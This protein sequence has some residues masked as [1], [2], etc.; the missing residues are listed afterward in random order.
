MQRHV[1]VVDAGAVE[2]AALGVALRSECIWTKCVRVEKQ[3]T[4]AR[5]AVDFVTRAVVLGHIDARSVDTIVLYLH[6]IVVALRRKRHRHSRGKAGNS[7]E[8]PPA[9]KATGVKE[10]S[11]RHL[12]VVADNE[13]VFEVEGRDAIER[14][15]VVRVDLFLDVR[16]LIVGLRVGVACKESQ[17]PGGAREGHFEAVVLRVAHVLVVGVGADLIGE[18]TARP[19]DHCAIRSRVD[20]IFLKRPTRRRAGG[21]L[22]GL[23]QTE[24]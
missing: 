24:A 3:F 23:T 11:D 13:V 1:E 21:D 4:L 9:G 22:R 16:G 20:E 12:I 18:R 7:G 6:Q 17:R 5:V 14:V 15:E 10:M 2:V 19:I 8:R